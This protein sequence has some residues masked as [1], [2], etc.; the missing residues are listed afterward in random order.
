V[1]IEAVLKEIE[2]C[3]SSVGQSE[4]LAARLDFLELIVNIA[5]LKPTSINSAFKHIEQM[6]LA[7][8]TNYAQSARV[9]LAIAGIA[10][11][12]ES[13]VQTTIQPL[14]SASAKTSSIDDNLE[15]EYC[16]AKLAEM[17]H[18]EDIYIHHYRRYTQAAIV[19]IR[20][21]CAYIQVPHV[22]RAASKQIPKDD[23][24][25]RLSGKYRRAYRFLLENIC[26]PDLSVKMVANEIGV[27]ERS[28]QLTFRAHVGQSPSEVIRQCRM[29]N[30]RLDL[31]AGATFNSSTLLDVA[32]KW[33]IRSRSSLGNSYQSAFNETPRQTIDDPHTDFN[34]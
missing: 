9:E 28:L 14:L 29:E 16:Q 3:K 25:T 12:K 18:R 17:H 22:L 5:Y 31:E 27:T 10:A 24:S 33:G 34:G 30:I 21:A 2:N 32:S 19:Q 15:F 11:D 7:G 6:A 1:R 8:F 13:W 23:I 26:N 20:R 4:L